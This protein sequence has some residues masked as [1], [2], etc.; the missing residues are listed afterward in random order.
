[1]KYQDIISGRFISRPNRFI[2]MVELEG[3]VI[4]AHVKNTGRCKELLIPGATVY[5]EP[6]DNP[7]RKT[8]FSL[9]AVDKEGKLVNMDSQAPNKVLEEALQN[10]PVHGFPKIES[11]R[12]EYTYGSSRLDFLI[13]EKVLVEVKGVTLEEKGKTYF[14]DAPTERGVRH[15]EELMQGL[16]Q[17]YEAIVCFIIQMSDVDS[18]SPNDIT[19]PEFGDTLRKAEKA[20]VSILAFQCD[21]TPGEIL[22]ADPVPVKLSPLTNA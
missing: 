18:F 1:M 12:R 20:G 9:I 7:N 14:P 16:E 5:L 17:G 13:N 11:L 2:A 8:R 10:G 6:S 4:K 15:L 3:E 19:H 21:V 22:L